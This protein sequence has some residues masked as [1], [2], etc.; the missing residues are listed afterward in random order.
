M[1]LMKWIL[2]S[3]F[4]LC[5]VNVLSLNAQIRIKPSLTLDV[6]HHSNIYLEKKDKVSDT[7]FTTTPGL[8][9]QLPAGKFYGEI[10]YFP[11]FVSYAN[12]SKSDYRA[13]YSKALL[14]FTPGSRLSL[15]LED[16]YN[17]AEVVGGEEGIVRTNTATASVKY[18]AG[19]RWS[20]RY[21]YSQ[22]KFTEPSQDVFS[23]FKGEVSALDVT[24][25]LSPA[26]YILTNYTY[27]RRNFEDS[28]AKDYN[29]DKISLGFHHRITPFLTGSITPTYEYRDY[30]EGHEELVG[31]NAALK[32]KSEKTSIV[33]SYGYGLF[34]TYL[35]TESGVPQGFNE[36][37]L[38]QLAYTRQY[39]KTERVGIDVSYAFTGKTSVFMNYAVLTNSYPE[40]VLLTNDELANAS[41]IKDIYKVTGIG[42]DYRLNKWVSLNLTFKNMQK[43]AE[44]SQDDFTYNNISF[45]L[46]GGIS[47]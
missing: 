44:N 47:F 30:K 45:G 13:D 28:T 20:V 18:Q 40:K 9:F 1:K 43:D 34:D 41:K 36:E 31:W 12:H 2:W 8:M 21:G 29:S 11:R 26:S 19:N 15:A 37:E 22:E 14:R 46:K 10:S 16:N 4:I 33:F 35:P 39:V 23:N 7:I 38:S 27:R 42:F 32:G 5:L 17:E 24:Y 6:E 3:M 25:N